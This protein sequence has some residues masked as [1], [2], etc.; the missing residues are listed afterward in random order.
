[1]AAGISL[2][3]VS[4]KV[5]EVRIGIGLAG[6]LLL[7]GIAMGFLHST[8]PSFG[9]APRAARWILMEFGLLFFLAGVGMEAGPD[10]AGAVASV[11]SRVLVAALALGVVPLAL[12]FLFGR[13]V[14]KMNSALL[15]GAMT[16]ALTSSA[17][18]RLVSRA[19]KSNLPAL[20]YAGTYPF[21]SILLALAGSIVIHM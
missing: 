7:S 15:L 19:A 20:G 13:Y 14:L 18:L 9:R 6:G 21:A 10:V 1:V 11:G 5:G 2:G 17:A 12:G 4:V 16:G 3:L 8:N